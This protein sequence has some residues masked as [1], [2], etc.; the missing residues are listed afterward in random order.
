MLGIPRG[1]VIVAAEVARALAAPLDVIVPR[2]IGAPGQPELAVGALAV[3]EG[4]EILIVDAAASA[5]L[6]VPREYL[7]DEARRQ[8][9]EIER[10][11]ALY[12]VEPPASVHGRIALVVDDG[13]ATGLTA[14]AAC[15]AVRGRG[16]SEVIVAAPVAPAQA[17]RE[18]EERGV[19]LE[20]LATPHFFA[21]VGQFY[22]D[23]G[24]VDDEAVREALRSVA[25]RER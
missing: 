25:R 13:L 2:K 1:G 12:R 4:Q 21:S 5:A 8:R 19:R 18:F 6:R 23:F 15:E 22:S 3:A 11:E 17:R 9:R 16:P 10:R 20:V 7:V 14:R 24:E